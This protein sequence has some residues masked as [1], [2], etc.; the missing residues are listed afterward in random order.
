[1]NAPTKIV[2]GNA[3]LWLG[4]CTDVLSTLDRVDAVIT[5]P[6]YGILNIADGL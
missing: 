1:M 6:P 4:D 5:D 3:E 2:I